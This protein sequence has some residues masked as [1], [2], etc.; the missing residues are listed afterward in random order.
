MARSVCFMAFLVLAMML[1]VAYEV[2]AQNI[3]MQAQNI[4]K[5]KSNTFE[6]LCITDSPCR[7][8]CIKEKF[9]DGHCSKLQRRCLCTKPC[10]FDNISNEAEMT[11]PE[12][13]KTLTE[14]LLEEEVMME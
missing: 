14:A 7:K 11:M 12:E 13:A 4:C 8:A 10:V 5:A 1:F 3:E 6:G 2:Q 9:T